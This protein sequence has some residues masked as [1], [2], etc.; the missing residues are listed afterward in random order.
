MSDSP[1]YVADAISR[2]RR[3]A[4]LQEAIAVETDLR[5]NVTIKSLIVA[6]RLDAERAMEELTDTS[7]EDKVSITDLIFRIRTHVHLR[8]TLE[9]ILRRGAAA[10][11]SIRAEEQGRPQGDE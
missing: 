4:I 9:A 11:Q 7:P 8:R 3:F 6:F 10:E 2:D 5:D 1:D